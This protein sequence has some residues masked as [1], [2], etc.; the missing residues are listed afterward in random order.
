MGFE[1]R[2]L[3]SATGSVAVVC[4]ISTL[5][6]LIA[7]RARGVRENGPMNGTVRVYTIETQFEKHEVQIASMTSYLPYSS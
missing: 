6:M 4:M 1:P 5:G 7:Q 2:G 3:P